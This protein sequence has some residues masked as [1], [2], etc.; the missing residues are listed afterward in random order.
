MMSATANVTKL[1]HRVQIELV[2]DSTSP[3]INLMTELQE[4][5]IINDVILCSR[6]AK[7]T[8][9]SFIENRHA[10]ADSKMSV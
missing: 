4:R 6:L 7:Q 10:N 3:V 5:I 1:K 8:I 2:N 9:L